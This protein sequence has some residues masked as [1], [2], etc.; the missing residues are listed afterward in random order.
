MNETQYVHTK[1]GDRV[2][3]LRD[4]HSGWGVIPAGSTATV[5]Y[6]RNGFTLQFD[7]CEHC[8]MRPTI[9]RVAPSAVETV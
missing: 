8:G 3:T 4:M 5:T 2:R 9:S 1:I 6:K 7:A